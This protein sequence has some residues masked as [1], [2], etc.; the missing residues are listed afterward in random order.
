[1]K[2]FIIVCGLA[3]CAA[4]LVA[5]AGEGN[6]PD[7]PGMQV[8]DVGIAIGGIAP[9][10][11]DTIHHSMYSQFEPRHPT[12]IEPNTRTWAEL[13]SL[14]SWLTPLYSGRAAQLAGWAASAFCACLRPSPMV[15]SLL[16]VRR[17]MAKACGQPISD[18]PHGPCP[19]PA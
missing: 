14:A 2:T 9:A 12:S 6:G 18:L 3:I 5:R 10:A 19:S 4:P 8:P 11:S 16:R 7:Y 13:N 17:W 15:S 1:M